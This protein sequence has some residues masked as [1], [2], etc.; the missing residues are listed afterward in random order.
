MASPSRILVKLDRQGRLVLPI[1]MREGFVNTPGELWLTSTPDGLLL[2]PTTAA[3]RVDTGAD[4]LPVLAMDR[5]VFNA[6]VL[7]AIDAERADR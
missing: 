2:Q 4:G 1:A 5:P 7:T 3:A 6:E